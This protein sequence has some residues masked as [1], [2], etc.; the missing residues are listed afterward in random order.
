MFLIVFYL[1]KN[2]IKNVITV[3]RRIAVFIKQEP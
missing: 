1:V 3:F 2:L